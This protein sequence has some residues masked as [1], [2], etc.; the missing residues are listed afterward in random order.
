MANSTSLRMVKTWINMTMT[1][2]HNRIHFDPR[3]KLISGMFTIVSVFLI[4]FD[5]PSAYI[6]TMVFLVPL[7]FF[8]RRY[9]AI[10]FKNILRVY[11]MI[12]LIT[13]HLPFQG[14][15]GHEVL[16]KIGIFTLY[17]PGLFYFTIV[18]MKSFFLLNMSFALSHSISMKQMISVLE[19]WKLP[20]WIIAIFAYL[21]RLIHLTGMEMN[22]L[23]M[24]LRSRNLKLRGT[25]ALSLLS[26]ISIV[27]LFRLTERSDRMYR[28]MLSRGF[29]GRFP[30]T[31]ALHWQYT[32]TIFLVSALTIITGYWVWRLL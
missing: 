26:K 1:E 27:Y 11:P 10:I 29:N 16:G 2:V 6:Y 23:K 28:A 13:I 24:S 22:R 9:I 7:W 18:Q 3:A 21:N 31:A 4:S 25:A 32:D 15:P 8:S 30:S 12:I 19:F 17:E 20:D 14:E 5:E